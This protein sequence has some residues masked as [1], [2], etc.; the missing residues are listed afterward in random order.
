MYLLHT[1][2]YGDFKSVTIRSEIF[3]EH[4]FTGLLALGPAI[5]TF[6]APRNESPLS[7][8][9]S[10]MPCDATNVTRTSTE[11]ITRILQARKT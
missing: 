11:N 7:V 5:S 2:Y 3:S 9:A 10:D 4:P 8:H 6:W 1:A